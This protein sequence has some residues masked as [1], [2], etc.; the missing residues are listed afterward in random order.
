MLTPERR[1][2][3]EWCMSNASPIA[4]VAVREVFDALDAAERERD[5]YKIH[6]DTLLCFSCRT[7]WTPAND[8]ETC[9]MAHRETWRHEWVTPRLARPA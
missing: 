9:G 5:A 8:Q 7:R 3:F 2:E 6:C 4:A 1:A